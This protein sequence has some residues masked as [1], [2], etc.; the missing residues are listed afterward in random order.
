TAGPTLREH[1]FKI[2]VRGVD[3]KMLREM[4]QRLCYDYPHNTPQDFNEIYGSVQSFSD[5]SFSF[6]KGDPN[7]FRDSIE[8]LLYLHGIEGAVVMAER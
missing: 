7:R 3:R 6:K 1:P 2:T 8:N 4:W 5:D